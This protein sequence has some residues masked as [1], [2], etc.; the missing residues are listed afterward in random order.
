MAVPSEPTTAA[1][2]EGIFFRNFLLPPKTLRWGGPRYHD[3]EV[4]L[5]SGEANAR[6]LN[7]SCGLSKESHVLDIGCG[8]GRLLTGILSAYEGSPNT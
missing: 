5:R 6:L 7:Q 4:Y 1:N 8:P 3:D 2:P